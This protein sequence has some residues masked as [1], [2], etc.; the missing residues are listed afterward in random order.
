VHTPDMPEVDSIR[1]RKSNAHRDRVEKEVAEI[2]SR[3]ASLY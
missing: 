2:N 1:M 3:L